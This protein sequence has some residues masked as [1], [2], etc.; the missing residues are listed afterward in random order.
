MHE[1]KKKLTIKSSESL[2]DDD[3]LESGPQKKLWGMVPQRGVQYQWIRPCRGGL[4][5]TLPS[6]TQSL[7]EVLAL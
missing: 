6:D 1:A 4:T 2:A 3:T 7:L 5:C